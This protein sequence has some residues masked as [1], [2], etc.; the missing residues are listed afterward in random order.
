MV[1]SAVSDKVRGSVKL[2]L[3][4][5]VPAF[6]FAVLLG[7]KQ[8]HAQDQPPAVGAAQ[9]PA[10]EQQQPVGESQV[11]TATPIQHL[12]VLMQENHSFDNYFGVYPGAD[13][14]PA[15]TCMPT[16]PFNPAS[17][18]CIKPFLIGS[19]EVELADPDHS[20]GTHKVQYNDGRMDGF[21]Y[22]LNQRNQD[23]RL[24]MG[25][26]DDSLLS[27]YWN[28]ADE[29][30]LF[31][32]FFS[33]AAG[34]SA[35]NHFFWVAAA[36]GVP[37]EGQ[38]PQALLADT[39][40]IFDRLEE[41]GI[42]WKF[43]VQ[44]Y[45]PNLTYRTQHLYPGNRAAQVIW[46]PVLNI[47]RFL[48]DPVLNSKIVDLTQYKKDLV[49]GTLPAVAF[50][51]PSGPSEHPPSNI[52]SGQRFVKTLVQMLMQSQYWSSSAF[53]WAYDDWGGW[54]DHVPPPQ[55]DDYGYG[56]R[57]PA[58]LVSPYARRGY[59]D[60]TDL[61]YTSILRFIEDNWHINPLTARDAQANSIG[62]AFDFS[63]PPREPTFLSYERMAKLPSPRPNTNMIYAVYGVGLA[64]AAGFV[65]LTMLRSDHYRRR[66]RHRQLQK[67][68]EQ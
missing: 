12:I 17:D 65:L 26:Y 19:N 45:D 16:D 32:R 22:A 27:Y 66:I 5:I 50:M 30:V 60:S 46:A 42:S 29:Y 18:E 68:A 61:D 56:F 47:D 57:V 64:A 62:N 49:D 51:V 23:G 24:A 6:A 10:R 41:A 14:I 15:D 54:Y 20:E 33:S 67:G 8:V 39:P 25:Y 43:Y 55:V 53:M 36:P 35:I 34:G 2:H 37:A 13:G 3:I 48:D 4:C 1:K 11:Q 7:A 21:V 59:I 38:T 31:D 63:R 52:E 9:P 58:L 28:V 40:T 44:N